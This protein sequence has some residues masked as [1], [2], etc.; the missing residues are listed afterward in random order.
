MKTDQEELNEWIEAV[1]QMD[2][3]QDVMTKFA[4][5]Y[6]ATDKITTAIEMAVR[7]TSFLMSP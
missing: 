2:F 7:K 6:M 1:G 5:Y 3:A 4:K